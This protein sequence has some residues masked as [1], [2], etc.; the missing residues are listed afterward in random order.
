MTASI[1]AVWTQTPEPT[2]TFTSTSTES[3]HCGTVTVSAVYPNPVVQGPVR[4]DLTNGCA[5][6]VRVRVFTSAYRKIE[7][8][9][10]T[11]TGR[12]TFMWNLTDEKGRRVSPGLYYF[13]FSPQGQK[14]VVKSVVVLR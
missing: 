9:S 14:R 3:G 1:T 12:L 6:Q 11:V 10:L 4:V 2:E 8:E 7:E 13:V 5:T